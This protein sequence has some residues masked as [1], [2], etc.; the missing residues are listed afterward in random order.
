LLRRTVLTL[1]LALSAT[2]LAVTAGQNGAS[3]LTTSTTLRLATWEGL[4]AGRI[5]PTSFNAQ[6]G[7]KY[8]V[9]TPFD[10][11]SVA[12]RG[13][14]K[15]YR[16]RLAS[17]SYKNYPAG[18]NGIVTF[19]PLARQVD[20]ACLSYDIRFS[21]TFDWSLGGKLPGLEGVRAGISPG[22]PTGG[23]N[24]GDKGW[25]GRLMWLGPKAYSWA[26]PTDEAVSYMYGPRQE[27]YYGD[28]VRWHRAFVRDSWHTVKMCY[29]M[30][31]VGSANGKLS[32]Y[33]DGVQVLN[34]TNH[35]YRL[36]SDVHISH[37]NWSIFRGGSSREWAGANESYI[38]FDNV[39]I[40]T[41]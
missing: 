7:S 40:T 37:L 30:N 32:A 18:N 14:G 34:V 4:P 1:A 12:S 15:A 5:S 36:R 21:P 16:L 17:G 24:P 20:N 26:G 25:S 31:T 33:L 22:T 11:S 6:L 8:T 2:L 10:D 23:G 13:T 9:T 29:T 35:V 41:G 3:A 38:D 27:S 19:V 28:N 39:R